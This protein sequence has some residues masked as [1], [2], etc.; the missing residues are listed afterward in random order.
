M[1]RG[2]RA[3]LGPAAIDFTAWLVNRRDWRG[4]QRV[5]R[6]LGDLGYLI[7]NRH[8]RVALDNVRR[9]FGDTLTPPAARALVR[10]CFHHTG[11]LF[12]EALRYPAL[13]EEE[14]EVLC[15]VEGKEHLDQALAQGKGVI[16]FTGHLGNWEVGALYMLQHGYHILPLSRPPRSARL[17]AKFR[18]IREKQGFRVIPVAEGM[19]GILRALRENAIVPILPDRYAKGQ[20][21][22]V[23]FFGQDTHVWHTPALVASRTGSPIIPAHTLRQ[24]DGSF[25]TE[26][27]APLYMPEQGDREAA[28]HE[29]TAQMMAL[30][31]AKIRR[32]PAQYPWTYQLWRDETAPAGNPSEPDTSEPI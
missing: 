1:R 31:E 3:A 10:Q 13:E 24:P 4:T 6:Q 19:R 29:V 5:G 21:V 27:D 25:V 12:M 26:L 32:Y 16:F 8:R 18:E 11:M 9:V 30:L 2:V 15:K 14:R 17:A 28:V 23:P 20:G 7:D 22:T